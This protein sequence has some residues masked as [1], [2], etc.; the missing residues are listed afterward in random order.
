[1]NFDKAESTWPPVVVGDVF[2]TG[3]NLMRDLSRHG[4]RTVGVD[5]NPDHQGFR[6]V[7][8]KAYLCPNPDYEPEAWVEFMRSLSRKCGVK[9]VFIPAADAF[10]SAL[11]RHAAQ[12]HD[13]YIFS[14]SA[15]TSQVIL[16][17]KERQYVLARQHGFPCPR[18][19]YILASEE[20]RSFASAAAFPCVLKPRHQRE[21]EG[22]PHGHP[23]RGTKLAVADSP[24]HLLAQYSLVAPYRPEA[25]VQ[26]IIAGPDSS[27][28]CYLSAY[29]RDGSR[30]GH[31]VVQEFRAYPISFGSA[32]I[33]QPVQDDEIETL[34]DSFLRGIGYVGLCEIEVKRDVRTGKVML[35]EVNPRFSATGD[36]ASYAGVEVGWLHYLDAIGVP[37]SPVRP[38]RFQFR[39][40]VLRLEV[41]AAFK[42]LQEGLITWRQLLRS[43]R[44]PL[45]FYDFDLKDW[46]VTSCTVGQL[47]RRVGGLMLR[48]AS[49][50]GV[51][52]RSG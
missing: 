27:K 8:G 11:G 39:H 45:E 7:Y 1:V 46:R 44:A 40:I 38:S 33:V 18:T 22:L 16:A 48:K 9:P 24:E 26:E 3:L 5:C 49:R 29:G 50:K 41:P 23:L 17:S 2:Q 36:A 19:E 31:C 4:V 21:W 20:L 35:I 6:S 15:L 10:V 32:S 52:P 12:M 28:Y 37:V 43:Y 30:L 51:V 47:L 34:C 14:E 25:V 42:Y 13:W